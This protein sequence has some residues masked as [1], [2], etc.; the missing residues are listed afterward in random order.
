MH[1]VVRSGRRDPIWENT[2]MARSTLARHRNRIAFA[3]T[4]AEGGGG[5]TGGQNQNTGGEGGGQNQNTGGGEGGSG[6]EGG[7]GDSGPKPDAVDEHGASLGFPKDTAVKDMN[8]AQ[9]ANYWR[10]QAKVQQRKAEA[11]ERQ[12]S[13]G[14]NQNQQ[15]NQNG[16]GSGTV[17]DQQQGGNEKTGTVDEAAIRREVAKDAATASI[18]TAL[19][20]RNKTAEEIDEIVDFLDPT[21]FLTAENKLDS[22]KITAFVTKTVPVRGGEGG[23]PGQGQQQQQSESKAAAGKAAAESRWGSRDKN[24]NRGQYGGLRR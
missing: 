4:S 17:R 20:A 1:D 12:Q 6:G 14:Q 10:N 22:A 19:A 23:N 9:R 3:R 16:G 11:L 21:R 24:Q 5:G 7:E 2:T 18:R 8:D 15:Q 13:G